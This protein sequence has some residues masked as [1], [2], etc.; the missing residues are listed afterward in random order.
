MIRH[1]TLKAQG[2][3][4][5]T[6]SLRRG[7]L[8]RA[9][10]CG[11]HSAGREQCADC[12]DKQRSLQRHWPNSQGPST[13]PQIVHD[14]LRAPG[15]SL[16]PTTL[17]MMESRFNYDFSKVRVHADA[18]AADSARAVDALAY[19]V[20][21]DI[22]FARGQYDPASGGGQ[23]L[24]AHELTHVIQQGRMNLPSRMNAK[25][26]N[27]GAAE[28]EADAI[29]QRVAGRAEVEPAS[30]EAR[31]AGLYR[32][33]APPNW[34]GVT[35][36]R[37]LS[38]LRVDPVVD[39]VASSFT[40]PVTVMPYAI[41][42]AIKHLSWE[43]YDPSDQMMSGSFT[44]LPG[45]P[46][47]T[48]M[49]FT[50]KPSHFSGASILEGKYIL[51]CVGHDRAHKPFVYTDRDFNVLR[52]DMPVGTALPTTY[53]NLKFTKYGKTDA[54]PPATPRYTVD[55]EL[56]FLP[57]ATV[58]CND[59]TFIQ[60]LESVDNQGRSQHHF[61]SADKAARQTT[62][63]W[64]VD[65]LAGVPSPYYIVG[66]DPSGKAADIAGYGVKGVGGPT[67]SKATLSDQPTWTQATTDHF[68]SCAICRSGAN[69][70]QLYGC[71]TW[72][73][74][75]DA[76]GKVTLMPRAFRQT[77]SEQFEEARVAWNTWRA[78]KPAAARPDEAPT[79][80]SP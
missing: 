35:G 43:L 23:R 67:P 18:T 39:F 77:P 69:R 59:I 45:H 48:T 33:P 10:A 70:G 40:T 24:L 73:F 53:G 80:R 58:T 54:N 31:P 21:R 36:V 62:L 8:Q 66:L 32:T 27:G 14:A 61:S 9:C 38:K 56:E 75:T 72:G 79:L 17:A 42:S 3:T 19:T 2:E 16:D 52:A 51:R 4:S 64:S 41:D 25:L 12:R 65:Q 6:P 28:Q 71:A 29:A 30:I 74:R 78:T 5:A 11:Q 44:T 47:S 55:V 37:D 20:G 7:K 22:V 50:L 46:T 13:A 60:S 63:A 15:E 57:K 26:E 1:L 76:A 68:E 49:P 34:G